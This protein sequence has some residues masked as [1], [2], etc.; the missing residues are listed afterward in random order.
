MNPTLKEGKVSKDESKRVNEPMGYNHYRNN[1][2]G[3][4]PNFHS[5]V[6]SCMGFH[7]NYDGHESVL[8]GTNENPLFLG[9]IIVNKS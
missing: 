8:D 2:V 7:V 5:G 6:H 9:W 4:I 1:G 3:D